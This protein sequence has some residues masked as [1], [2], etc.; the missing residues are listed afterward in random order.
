MFCSKKSNNMINKVHERVLRG[1]LREDLS[2]FQ[3]LL[4]NNEGI[5][6]HHKNIQSLMIEMFKIKNDLALLIL[7]SMFGRRN[8]SYNFRNFQ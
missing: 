1:I 3:S 8:E 5:C 4:Q 2:D 6:R 7:N